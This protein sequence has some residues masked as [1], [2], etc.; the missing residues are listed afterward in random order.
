MFWQDEDGVDVEGL[1]RRFE[2][3]NR[4]GRLGYYS[5]GELQELFDWYFAEENTHALRQVID[6][7]TYLYPDWVQVIWWRSRLAYEEE[8]YLE[9]Y[10]QGLRAFEELPLSS[11]VYEHLIAVSVA[12]GRLDTARWIWELWRDEP[13]SSEK[14]V[15][16]ARVFAETCFAYQ[17]WEG[18]IPILWQA[19]QMASAQHELSLIRLLTYAYRKSG[20]YDIALHEFHRAIWESPERAALWLGL[21]QIYF[22]KMGYAQ[23]RQA[24]IQSE[25]LLS[26]LDEPPSAL[27]AE[28]YSLRAQIEEAYGNSEMAL[29]A[30]LWAR[31]YAPHRPSILMRLFEYQRQRGEKDSA[32]YYLEKL[33]R[34]AMHLPRVR[35]LIADFYWDEKRYGQAI[36]YYQ[37]LLPHKG[38]RVYAIGR[39]MLSALRLRDVSVLKKLIRRSRQLY[40]DAANV[41]L[42]WVQL[43]F[44]ER[45][46]AFA[47][48]L[49]EQLLRLRM[50]MP[51]AAYYWHAALAARQRQYDLALHSLEIGLL[52]NPKELS[53]FQQATSDLL[54]PK[55]FHVLIQRYS[56]G[57]LSAA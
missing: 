38:Y 9:A 20:R 1:L 30:W 11:E 39:A 22:H 27:L 33:H 57:E 2:S 10:V 35:Q 16:G 42:M 25:M 12:V 48:F 52:A 4:A 51:A 28:L 36:V 29:W 54:L 50:R 31:E 24:L 32:Y 26:V 40:G 18:A 15:W 13:H 34:Y 47:L 44:A 56:R 37:S 55:P 45:E 46:Y 53:L 8:R 43:A 17:Q 49:T 5:Q 3:E 41:W 19:W 14:Q 7:A 6:H 23:A 21:A